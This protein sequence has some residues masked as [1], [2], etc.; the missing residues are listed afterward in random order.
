MNKEYLIENGIVVVIDEYK[1]EREI[2][3]TNNLEEILIYESLIEQITKKINNNNKEILLVKEDYKISKRD[4]FLGIIISLYWFTKGISSFLNP[5]FTILEII[6][7]LLLSLIVL[8]GLVLFYNIT[9][10]NKKRIK[11][12]EK[13]QSFL[14]KELIKNKKYLKELNYN[15]QKTTSEKNLEFIKINDSKILSDLR[16]NSYLHYD[17]GLNEEKYIRYYKHNSL[18]D[19]LSGRYSLEDI[20]KIVNYLEEDDKVKKRTLRK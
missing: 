11:G 10:T 16:S 1:N 2:E 20:D 15:K 6:L 4:L 5:S 18:Y 8:G 19:K 17:Y 13:E 14:E 7:T 9:I 12:L 3:Y